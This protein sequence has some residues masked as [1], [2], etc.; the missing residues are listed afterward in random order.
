MQD[1]QEIHNFLR[2]IL[3]SYSLIFMDII[4][5]QSKI[6]IKKIKKDDTG[7]KKKEK[8]DQY[9]LFAKVKNLQEINLYKV[10]WLFSY[11][12]I[13]QICSNQNM[14]KLAQTVFI[15]VAIWRVSGSLG[16]SCG[17]KNFLGRV[18]KSQFFKKILVK[19]RGIWVN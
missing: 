19:I 12:Y 13:P 18:E 16:L 9:K 10:S 11:Y 8:N 6:F 2:H 17:R 14:T 7:F 3:D 4:L 1:S 15:I 5:K